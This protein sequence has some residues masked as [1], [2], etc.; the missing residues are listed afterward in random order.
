MENMKIELEKS[1]GFTKKQKNSSNIFPT[2][3]LSKISKSHY[4]RGSAMFL[5]TPAPAEK[6]NSRR[7]KSLHCPLK[8]VSD[9]I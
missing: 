3:V 5:M 7:S 2:Q 6:A 9:I 8:K 1:L 4:P